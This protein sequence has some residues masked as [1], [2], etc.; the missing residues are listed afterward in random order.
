MSITK[1]IKSRPLTVIFSLIVMCMIGFSMGLPVD[2]GDP[3]KGKPAKSQLGSRGNGE[4][5]VCPIPVVD[6]AAYAAKSAR[7]AS[8]SAPL[9][10]AFI[11][12][13]NPGATQI[14]YIDFNGYEAGWATLT[15]FNMDGD[16]NS[17]NDEER[18]VIIDTWFACSEDFLP[19]NIDVTTEEPPNGFLGQRAVVD[20]SNLYT[21][22]WAY[23]GAWASTSGEIAYCYHGD[24]TWQ[25]TAACQDLDALTNGEA[26]A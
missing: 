20:G 9:E 18:Q 8:F 25:W 4:L 24:D 21:Y 7:V 15:P 14:L 23:G 11:L 12:H 17:F 5:S 2:A 19:Y 1:K 13:S 6:Q 26:V 3:G 22:S 10:D 16:P